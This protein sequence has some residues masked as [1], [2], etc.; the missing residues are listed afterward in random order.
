MAEE[1]CSGATLV[2]LQV[3]NGELS[4]LC[5]RDHTGYFTAPMETRDGRE[6][7][8][9]AAS[10]AADEELH[11]A[12]SPEDL[13]NPDLWSLTPVEFL[14]RA[15]KAR[16]N[17]VFIS[18]GP[19]PAVAE[20][21]STEFARRAKRAEDEDM[22]W[23]YREC[24]AMTPVPVS[25]LLGA[26]LAAR[27][28]T[29]TCGTR[30]DLR[31]EFVNVLQH[32]GVRAR[33]Q[34]AVDAFAAAAAGSAP[35]ASTPAAVG[36]PLH[37]DTLA[38]GSGHPAPLGVSMAATA[39]T[40]VDRDSDSGSD[41]DSDGAFVGSAKGG[42]S[43]HYD[44]HDDS[45]MRS[46]GSAEPMHLVAQREV[47]VAAVSVSDSEGAGALSSASSGGAPKAA[48][49]V[50]RTFRL[51]LGDARSARSLEYL[52]AHGITHVVN[53][54]CSDY[55]REFWRPHRKAGIRYATINTDDGMSYA[56]IVKT[57]DPGAQWP[58]AM[59]LLAEALAQGSSALVHCRMGMNRSATTAG[60][61][62]VLYGFAPTFEH[63]VREMQRVRRV[64]SPMKAYRDLAQRYLAARAH[65]APSA[66]VATKP[67]G[68][69]AGR[70]VAGRGASAGA[71]AHGG[72][73]ASAMPVDAETSV[74]GTHPSPASHGTHTKTE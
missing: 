40:C 32:A 74:M 11:V 47:P 70:K 13:T 52:R 9:I 48:A 73:G 8:S 28:V 26:T 25:E 67:K 23:C 72:A 2:A 20:Y 58:A 62:A 45:E 46:Y 69:W 61:F 24:T 16:N 10:R 54:C 39:S 38:A 65:A 30:V 50:T 56:S 22:P 12:V 71:V 33:L 4:V 3:T 51:Y 64:V 43:F 60:I 49:S 21:T 36:G 57:Q 44:W 41:S 18:R 37:A 27:R 1:N 68:K 31:F 42:R 35:G 7:R 14:T 19:L 59:A 66:A 17:A 53:C 5:V 15:G 55:P 6:R 63:A 29:A 34:S